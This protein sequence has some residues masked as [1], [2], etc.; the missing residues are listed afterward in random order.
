[1][2]R[3]KE[4]KSYYISLGI[5]LIAVIISLGA[6]FM[7]CKTN[8]TFDYLGA[9]TGIIG[10]SVAVYTIVQVID[11]LTL[12]KRISNIKKDLDN[13]VSG[14]RAFNMAHSCMVAAMTTG[15]D[16]IS[17]ELMKLSLEYLSKDES[18]TMEDRDEIRTILLSILI[19][20]L[21]AGY[22]MT[23]EDCPCLIGYCLT[24]GFSKTEPLI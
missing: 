18:V 7:S 5:S 11:I 9:I 1:M 3:N 6:F 24:C 19:R 10:L 4:N 13:R 2:Q 8:I 21:N 23:N 12:E 14:I 22:K 15:R 17:V 16:D 20:M